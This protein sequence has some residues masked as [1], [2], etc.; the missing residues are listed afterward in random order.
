M[1]E[2]TFLR[3]HCS[4][5]RA[6]K[7]IFSRRLIFNFQTGFLSCVHLRLNTIITNG[8]CVICIRFHIGKG[9]GVGFVYLDNRQKSHILA[10]TDIL[11]LAVVLIFFKSDCFSSTLRVQPVERFDVRCINQRSGQF[12]TSENTGKRITII[13]IGYQ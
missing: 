6:I 4:V 2:F 10:F 8:E 7:Q 5:G 1:R 13:R 11:E 3:F 12:G 9:H